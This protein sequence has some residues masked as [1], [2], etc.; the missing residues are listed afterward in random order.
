MMI[1][2]QFQ[3]WYKLNNS[4]DNGL[5]VSRSVWSNLDA[6]VLLITTL[7]WG[8]SDTSLIVQIL[9]G[10]ESCAYRWVPPHDWNSPNKDWNRQWACGWKRT[11]CH[12]WVCVSPRKLSQYVQILICY[13]VVA[14]IL[15][16]KFSKSR[17][18]VVNA[19]QSNVDRWRFQRSIP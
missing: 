9:M 13:A 18:L 10:I 17:K 6:A 19:T 12:P 16:F 15:L 5:K 14:T 1:F 4:D 2:N 8:V 11:S 3:I 7:P